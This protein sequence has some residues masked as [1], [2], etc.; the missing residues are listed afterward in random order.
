ML[1]ADPG[2][3]RGDLVIYARLHGVGSNVVLNLVEKILLQDPAARRIVRS[4][5]MRRLFKAK[6][7]RMSPGDIHPATP[8]ACALPA[9]SISPTRTRTASW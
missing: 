7:L 1:R 3:K 9:S 2:D 8:R 5:F 4:D 6:V